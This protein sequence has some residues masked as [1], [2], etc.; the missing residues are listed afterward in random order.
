MDQVASALEGGEDRSKAAWIREHNVTIARELYRRD[1]RKHRNQLATSLHSLG[2]LFH[3][4][5]RYS[6]ALRF[7]NEAVSLWR[8]L[9]S[10][11]GKRMKLVAAF[12]RYRNAIGA[13]ARMSVSVFS[14]KRKG[15]VLIVKAAK[16][17]GPAKDVI[18]AQFARSL[19]GLSAILH[20]SNRIDE[21]C[22][23]D[24]E[25]LRIVHGLY[26]LEP[27]AHRARLAES[28]N[29]SSI[30]LQK[31]GRADDALIQAEEAVTLQR[32]LFQADPTSH[33]EALAGILN[34]WGVSLYMAERFPEA[35]AAAQEAIML[36][37]ELF[38]ADPTTHQEDLAWHLYIGCLSLEWDD[39]LHEVLGAINGIKEAVELQRQLASLDP[40][41]HCQ[42]L[43]IFLE[44][45]LYLLERTGHA[46]DAQEISAELA[47]VKTSQ[48]MTD[49]LDSA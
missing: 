11:G 15:G 39:T 8:M 24:E 35:C 40:A 42:R 32:E 44:H 13:A 46:Q 17:L 41:H 45:Y 19:S 30:S 10:R 31:A 48:G 38:Q 21:A 34:H 28:L 25:E 36:Q 43:I 33:Q 9:Y 29:S 47:A 22:I 23:A 3:Q 4:L 26:A 5:D 14:P 49:K 18:G 27:N 1:A 2:E 12:Q 16:A 37:R 20:N 6:V 7:L